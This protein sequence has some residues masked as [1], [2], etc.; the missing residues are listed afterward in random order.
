M[1]YKQYGYYIHGLAANGKSDV[2]MLEM[3]ELL[4]REEND[5]CSKRGLLPNTDQQTFEMAIPASVNEHYQR[6]RSNLTGFSQTSD[7]MHAFGGHL[8]KVDKEK[9]IPTYL[10]INK[11]LTGFIEHTFK[12]VD[13]I[14]RDKSTLESI[15]DVESIEVRDKGFFYNGMISANFNKICKIISRFLIDNGHSFEGVLF[16]SLELTLITFEIMFFIIIDL[17]VHSFTFAAVLTFIVSKV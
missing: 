6:L 15:F 10:L 2:N 3:Y 14:V 4:E 9:L 1:K 11:F 12:D 16:Y 5:L 7:R 17:C 8:S 13:Y